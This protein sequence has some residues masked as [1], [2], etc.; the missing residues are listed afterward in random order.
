[1]QVENRCLKL[2]GPITFFSVLSDMRIVAAVVCT[3]GRLDGRANSSFSREFFRF[4]GEAAISFLVSSEFR[5]LGS[6][7][8]LDLQKGSGPALGEEWVDR[9]C[10]PTLPP[11]HRL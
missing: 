3:C 2:Q 1:M 4:V 10:N 11:R 8:H 7:S 9:F 5:F 6:A